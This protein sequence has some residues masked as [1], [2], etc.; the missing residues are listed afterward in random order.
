[1]RTVRDPLDGDGEQ[2]AGGH[3]GDQG[4]DQD[5][6]PGQA[7]EQPDALEAE[8]EL[9]ADEGAHDED[10]GVREVNELEHPIDHRVAQRDQRV[11]EPEDDAV[12]EDLRENV[13][14]ELEVHTLET[15]GGRELPARPSPSTASSPT[16]L[17]FGRGDGQLLDDP[18][19]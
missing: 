12:E 4:E 11:H 16:L 6:R 3:A 1:Q 13:D 2:P 8:E 14:E 19:G 18:F 7:V 10:L 5:E 15:R 17:L 9:D